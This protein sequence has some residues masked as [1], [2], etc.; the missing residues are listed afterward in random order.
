MLVEALTGVGSP[1]AVPP[2]WEY[3]LATHLVLNNLVVFGSVNANRS[4]YD[5]A[6]QALSKADKSWLAGLISRRVDPQHFDEA[7]GR[8]PEDI[9]AV[10]EWSLP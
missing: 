4:H 7:L 8:G 6:A 3:S 5:P 2:T 10:V 9:K 1:M